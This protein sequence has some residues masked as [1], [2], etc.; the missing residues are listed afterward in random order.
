MPGVVWMVGVQ[1]IVI[2]VKVRMMSWHMARAALDQYGDWGEEQA[3]IGAVVFR[4]G[5]RLCYP[6]VEVG[7]WDFFFISHERSLQLAFFFF[8]K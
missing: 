4:V 2:A 7:G 1:Y 8:L 5:R 6:Q 3:P